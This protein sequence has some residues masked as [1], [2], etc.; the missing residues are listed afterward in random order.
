MTHK[1]ETEYGLTANELLDA[2]DRRFRAKV[3]LEGAV[4][5]VHL[6]KHI[7][8]A[9]KGGAIHRYEVHDL[10]GYPDYTLW[11]SEGPA[12]AYRVEC[13]TVRDANEA[14]REEGE[15]VAYKV[16]TQKTRASKG[17]PS[18]RFY[19]IDQFEILAVCLGKKTHDWSQFL[20]VQTKHLSRHPKYRK[21]LAVMHRV[22]LP[23]GPIDPPW[24]DSLVALLKEMAHG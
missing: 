23:A 11:V 2:I 16:E 18:S 20:Y 14:Y 4:A 7:D 15:I 10:D 24:Y 21:K 8:K 3:T 1:L 12:P 19:G 13:K 17:D 22:P 5:E 6:G 9:K